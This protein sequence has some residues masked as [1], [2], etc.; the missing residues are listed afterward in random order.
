M[1]LLSTLRPRKGSTHKERRVGRGDGSGWGGTA[2]K[3]HKGQKAR[4]GAPIKR[5]FEGGQT[6]MARRL[7]KFGFTNN[8]FKTSYEVLNLDQLELFDGEISPEILKEKGVVSKTSLVKI[9]GNGKISKS[10]NV[11]AHKFSASA[12][13]AIEAAGGTTEVIK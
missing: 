13:S 10:I 8:K 9:L 12:K 4:S 5:G 7:P 2:G 3:G 11:K 1:S 6:P